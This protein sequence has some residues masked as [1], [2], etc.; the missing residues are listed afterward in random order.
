MNTKI[1]TNIDIEAPLKQTEAG[2]IVTRLKSRSLSRRDTPTYRE[3]LGFSPL[4]ASQLDVF[5][6]LKLDAAAIARLAGREESVE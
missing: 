6:R 4:E 1:K 3:M 5:Q 2:M